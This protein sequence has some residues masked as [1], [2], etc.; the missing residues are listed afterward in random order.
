VWHLLVD[1][2]QSGKGLE[3]RAEAPIEMK[4]LIALSLCVFLGSVSVEDGFASVSPQLKSSR[5]GAKRFRIVKDKPTVYISFDHAGRREP[6]LNGEGNQG[7]WLRLHNNTRWAVRLQMSGVPRQYGDANLFY[8]V[9][10]ENEVV[11]DMKCHVCS[12]NKLAPGKPILFSL[13]REYLNK[14]LAIRISFSYDWE[15]D[16]RGSTS[17]EPQHYVYFYSSK[18]PRTVGSSRSG[19][20]AETLTPENHRY[21]DHVR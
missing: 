6:L 18:L 19:S 12:S 3:Q 9:L 14:D 15:E 5:E 21:I 11:I 4:K 10:S 16:E 7:I 2:R 8:E 1:R 17:L 13:P 20:V